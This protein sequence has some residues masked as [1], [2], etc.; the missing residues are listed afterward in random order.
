MPGAVSASAPCS[1]GDGD[2]LSA[3]LDTEAMLETL[4]AQIKEA[5]TGMK[6]KAK[7]EKGGG[8]KGD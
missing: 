2:A 4:E 7:E 1:G 6:K 3:S 5:I 8:E